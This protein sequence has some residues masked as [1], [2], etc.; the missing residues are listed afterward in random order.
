MRTLVNFCWL[1]FLAASAIAEQI[2]PR[3]LAAGRMLANSTSPDGRYCLLGITHGDTTAY[4]VVL[5]TADRTKIM[6]LTKMVSERAMLRPLT[7]R[8]SIVWSPDSKRVAV[9][10]AS[11]KH[12]AVTIYRLAS[13]QFEPLEINDLLSAACGKWGISGDKLISSGQ[14]PLEWL[15]ANTNLLMIAVAGRLKDGRRLRSTFGV[16]AP[17]TGK[18]V[19]Q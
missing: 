13:E 16:H 4:A 18:S 15:R 19:P 17:L 3:H 2:E 7:N 12:S 8:I 11:P 14:R 5:A 9:H 10:D 1:A 6:A